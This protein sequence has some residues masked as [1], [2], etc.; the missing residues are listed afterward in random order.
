[1]QDY[2][3]ING[4]FEAADCYI[5]YPMEIRASERMNHSR[6]DQQVVMM[7]HL[8]HQI[9]YDQY[10][11]ERMNAFRSLRKLLS[12]TDDDDSITSRCHV[13]L[14]QQLDRKL[15]WQ[16][17]YDL[18]QSTECI[19]VHIITGVCDC[20]CML[21][22]GSSQERREQSF[23]QLINYLPWYLQAWKFLARKALILEQHEHDTQLQSIVQIFRLWA[24]VKQS[25][26]KKY[27]IR[28]TNLVTWLS[29]FW[30]LN[31][32]TQSAPRFID[33]TMRLSLIGLIKDL[34]NRASDTDK[35]YMHNHL[36]EMVLDCRKQQEASLTMMEA[37]SNVLWNW[38]TVDRLGR[39]MAESSPETWQALQYML[40]R[41]GT[42]TTT[43]V[44]NN[45]LQQQQQRSPAS[46][47][48]TIRRQAMSVVGTMVAAW[49][50]KADIERPPGLLIQQVWLVPRLLDVL[51]NERDEDIRRRSIRT[52]RC[53]ATCDWGRS[54]IKQSANG[55][56]EL[57]LPHVLL[58][59]LR[60]RHDGPEIQC[61]A[62]QTLSALITHESIGDDDQ[63]TVY[64]TLIKAL[65]HVI[66]D[67]IAV[68]D[69]C[70]SIS[71]DKL[72][73]AAC[74]TFRMCLVH[75][76]SDPNSSELSSTHLCRIQQVL[77][78]NATE[79]AFHLQ[80]SELLLHLTL[81]AHPVS[82]SAMNQSSLLL[83]SPYLDCISILL[84][85]VGPETEI[86][87]TNAI[88]IVLRLMECAEN[89]KPLADHDRLLTSLVNFCLMHSGSQKQ[90]VKQV[91]L[92]IVPE[93]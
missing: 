65:A 92:N 14:E 83:S 71:A 10:P 56:E 26:I 88:D 70:S 24:Q 33:N 19:N 68:N 79:P 12:R 4:D 48:I 15:S 43:K 90:T 44:L 86:S 74:E 23:S 93:I 47:N 6:G 58:E 61:Q 55:A 91:I 40:Q 50:S 46:S 63:N 64:E 66:A 27:L 81:T 17:S 35:E 42:K 80:I 28:S 18:Q 38:A 89:K 2:G 72:T 60:N 73:V 8:M 36:L 22:T 7:G 9:C 78:R 51:Q 53:L 75:N 21:W 25:T 11:Q 5:D 52:M 77:E 87:R 45:N 62:C 85:S 16:L 76:H 39:S 29:Q 57:P 31:S 41:R 37:A 20:L 59:I 82:A 1:M 32:S 67:P 34:S 30:I 49:T 84:G 13:G 69:S 3:R 54:F